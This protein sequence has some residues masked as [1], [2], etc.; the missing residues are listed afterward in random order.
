MPCWRAPTTGRGSGTSPPAARGAAAGGGGRARGGGSGPLP[1]GGGGG[2]GGGGGV[3]GGW[4][5]RVGG[6]TPVGLP[7]L[8]VVLWAASPPFYA[9][10]MSSLWIPLLLATSGII[11]RGTAFA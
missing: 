11:F 1:A 8:L 2:G 4:V 10:V 6:A 7:F 9:S 3:V 5:S